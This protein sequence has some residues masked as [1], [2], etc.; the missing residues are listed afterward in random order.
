MNYLYTLDELL[1]MAARPTNG[2]ACHQCGRLWHTTLP[3]LSV[4]IIEPTD[5][6][7]RH[8]KLHPAYIT[9]EPNK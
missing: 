3:G 5:P 6:D 9:E 7:C 4:P 1:T 8:P 2:Y